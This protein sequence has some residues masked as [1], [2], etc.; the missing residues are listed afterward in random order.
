[1]AKTPLAVTIRIDLSIVKTNLFLGGAGSLVQAEPLSIRYTVIVQIQ[2]S[3]EV[4]ARIEADARERPGGIVATDGDGTL[5]TGDVGE[6]LFHA[7][8]EG[9]RVE[10]AALE[11]LRRTARHHDLSDAGSGVDI[12]RRIYAAYLAGGYAEERMCELMTWCFAGWTRAEVAGFARHVVDWGRLAERLHEEVHDVLDRARAAGL[13]ALLVSASPLA[14][15]REAGARVGFG[16]EEVVAAVARFEGEVMLPEVEAPIPYGP[17]KVSRLLERIGERRPV[18]AAFGDNAF[19]VALLASARVPVAVRPKPRLR[20][21]ASE[22]AG[23]VE[24]AAASIS[25]AGS[26]ARLRGRWSST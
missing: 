18:Y 19:D 6:D 10:P 22:V 23:L 21:R 8:L 15:V 3:S 13:G 4:W 25:P 2:T 26:R 17:G 12:A 11:G 9:G 7:F 14:V 20:A 1:M 16:E 5:W 24:L